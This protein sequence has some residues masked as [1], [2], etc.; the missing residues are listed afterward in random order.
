MEQ[1]E[2]LPLELRKLGLSDK[3][4]RVYFAALE[5]G[6]TSM[7]KIAQKAGI[8]RPTAYEV[9]KKLK[10]KELIIESKE[11]GHHY[12]TAESPDKLLG[13]LRRQQKEI[14]EKERE[15]IRIIAAL[16]AK[17]Y[18]K[19]EKEIR[20]FQ[21]KNGIETL[22]DEFST[23]SAKQI[24]IFITDNKIWPASER[25]AIYQKIKKRLGK[26]IIKEIANTS[27]KL[28]LPYLKRKIINEE[29]FKGIV[30]L[31]DKTVILL[32]P[33]KGLLIENKIVLKLLRTFFKQLWQER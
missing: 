8:S 2:I 18:L 21:E 7:Q 33:V 29:L 5:L 14:Q 30:I 26:V 12:F 16:R 11:K 27:Q 25:E 19:S 4:A 10:D 24:Y 1:E 9:V 31:S 20:F 32:S 23:T 6:Y 22:L 13:I 15:F 28:T 17:Y 3:E